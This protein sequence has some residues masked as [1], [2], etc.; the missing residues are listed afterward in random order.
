MEN[1][2]K[3][4]FSGTQI[5]QRIRSWRKK[6]KISVRELSEKSGLSAIA[7]SKIERNQVSPTLNSLECLALAMQLKLIDFFLEDLEGDVIINQSKAAV[8]EKS[9]Q[10]QIKSLA[11][12][13]KDQYLEPYLLS[14]QPG[15]EVHCSGQIGSSE[16]FVWCLKGAT[17]F[18]INRKDY[19]IQTS[20]NI[21]FRSC[22]PF[23]IHNPGKIE[24]EMLFIF[25][26]PL[27]KQ[28]ANQLLR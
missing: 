3:S 28:F 25:E 27:G 17:T 8:L 6:H 22:S 5:G 18:T 1:N 24:N 4:T 19:Q 14:L 16:V 7:I 21:L 13:L 11:S 23:T 20:E 10:L 2:I 12:G 9:P 26:A 15:Q